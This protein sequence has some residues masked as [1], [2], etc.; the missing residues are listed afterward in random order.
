M[1]NCQTVSLSALWNWATKIMTQTSYIWGRGG[2]PLFHLFSVIRC[3][4]FAC[5]KCISQL[6]LLHKHRTHL[7]SSDKKNT[8]RWRRISPP[9]NSCLTPA[10]TPRLQKFLTV[11][12]HFRLMFVDVHWLVRLNDYTGNL[13]YSIHQNT[14]LTYKQTC[15]CV[16]SF[17]IVRTSKKVPLMPVSFFRRLTEKPE[18]KRT[19]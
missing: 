15:L 10:N 6:L 16:N 14:T 12:H 7:L 8:G 2:S 19:S 1:I 3:K 5:K 11:S 17:K 18:N 4:K 13:H 9:L